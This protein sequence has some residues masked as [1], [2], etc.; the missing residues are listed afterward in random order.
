[1]NTLRKSIYSFDHFIMRGGE[2]ATLVMTGDLEVEEG[3][4]ME[5]IFWG[6]LCVG[7]DSGFSLVS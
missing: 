7:W 1:M 5:L 6:Y 4:H 3:D 2:S